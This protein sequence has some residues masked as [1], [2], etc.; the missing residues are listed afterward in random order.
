MSFTPTRSQELGAVSPSGQSA[1]RS[2]G[3]CT[4]AGAGVARLQARHE[5]QRNDR[6]ALE[7][8]EEGGGG[9][10]APVGPLAGTGL[11]EVLQVRKVP[12]RDVQVDEYGPGCRKATF[13][14]PP[15][16]KKRR[17]Q[18]RAQSEAALAA[19]AQAHQAGAAAAPRAAAPGG[20]AGGAV[21]GPAGEASPAGS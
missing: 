2:G 12:A 7:R 6:E 9:P 21:A 11:A 8:Q 4:H 15:H 1:A 3:G 5:R 17:Q 10:P 20:E 18:R 14:R 19:A 13:V 16:K